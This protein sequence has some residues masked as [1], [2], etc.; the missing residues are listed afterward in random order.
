MKAILTIG[1]RRYLV[2]CA[3]KALAF[4]TFMETAREVHLSSLYQPDTIQLHEEPV[5]VQVETVRAGIKIK[6]KGAKS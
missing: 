3:K 6:T 4:A 5:D 2:P 1:H